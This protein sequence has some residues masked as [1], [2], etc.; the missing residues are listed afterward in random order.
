MPSDRESGIIQFLTLLVASAA[1]IVL[2]SIIS[3][4]TFND[5]FAKT[6]DGSVDSV[7]INNRQRSLLT[8]V[9]DLVKDSI[10]GTTD[11]ISNID[12]VQYNGI[13]P[14]KGAPLCSSHDP[15]KYHGIWDDKSGCHYDHTHGID[16]STT[17]FADIYK[18]WNQQ[19][20]YPWQTPNEN[21]SKHKGY[22]YLYT[23][24]KDGCEQF[25]NITGFY[26][27]Y[28][29]ITHALYVVHSM[30]T[31]MEMNARYHSFRA[32]FRICD[33]ATKTQCGF[34]Q[35]GGWSDYGVLDCPYKKAQ[36]PLPVD[37]VPL[38]T[39]NGKLPDNVA[40]NQPPYRAMDPVA[41]LDRSLKSGIMQQIWSSIGP[42]PSI[43]AY[44]PDPFN[45]FF[46]S[47]WA[48][49]D[50][51]GPIDPAMPSMDN[52]ICKDGSCKYNH[53]Q[54]QIFT[55]RLTNVPKGPFAGF[56]DKKGNISSSCKSESADCIPLVT[57]SG[58]PEGNAVLN[59]AARVGKAEYAQI[60][61]YDVCFNE[62]GSVGMCSDPK[63]VSAGW[64][65]PSGM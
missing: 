61:D 38:S 62:D 65:K 40:F 28:N 54:F 8:Q 26:D 42:N 17:I 1:V 13:K 32:V 33:K 46:G 43:A 27:K 23:E 12:P 44:Y 21:T 5:S 7:S 41:D 51:W 14:F 56:T 25:S 9:T 64:I 36:C 6:R 4:K 57:T 63:T 15:T 37:P 48:S 2:T 49:S 50:G 59:R 45:R 39:D 29:C 11:S 3:H 18:S 35:T 24:A 20:S 22:L 16:P 19:I 52:F 60:Y 34:V 58:T 47:V 10:K 31:V 53:S 55:L 30:G